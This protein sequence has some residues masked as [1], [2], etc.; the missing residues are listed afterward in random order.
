MLLLGRGR[1]RRLLGGSLQLERQVFAERAGGVLELLLAEG[2]GPAGG[3]C[4]H[5]GPRERRALFLKAT[6]H[7]DISRPVASFRFELREDG[8]PELPP[9]VHGLGEDG[10]CRPCS[11]AEFLLALCTSDF[12]IHGTIHGVAHDTELQETVITMAA[13]CVLNQTLPL[14]QPGPLPRTADLA[15]GQPLSPNQGVSISAKIRGGGSE[16]AQTGLFL[17]VS[18]RPHR[19]LP[20]GLISTL[21]LGPALILWPAPYSLLFGRR[22]WPHPAVTGLPW[23]TCS[24]KWAAAVEW[25]LGSTLASTH[26]PHNM[27]ELPMNTL[28]AIGAL[29]SCTEGRSG[30]GQQP[31]EPWKSWARGFA[32]PRGSGQR[33]A[34]RVSTQASAVEAALWGPCGV[35]THTDTLPAAQC[36]K[37]EEQSARCEPERVVGC[38]C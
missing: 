23:T 16:G 18:S 9:Q 28:P 2:L 17:S 15:S 21:A 25:A 31:L 34:A 36:L 24:Q 11:D 12:V 13:A 33:E 30:C 3:Q 7:R 6:L 19:G 38:V 8:S 37:A 1:P 14:F 26:L 32:C 27:P 20:P 29:L 5:W 10:A 22:P 35:C 4:A